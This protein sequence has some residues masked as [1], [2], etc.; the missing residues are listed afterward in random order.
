[1]AQK[2]NQKLLSKSL[3]D[4]HETNDD[5]TVSLDTDESIQLPSRQSLTAST[6]SFTESGRSMTPSISNYEVAKTPHQNFKKR[7]A[8]AGSLDTSEI[9]REILNRKPPDPFD[10]LPP[11]PPEPTDHIQTFFDA[12]ASTVRT[13]PAVSI[14]R[15]KLQISK[16][17]GEEELACAVSAPNNFQQNYT[18]WRSI[19]DQHGDQQQ[20]DGSDNLDKRSEGDKENQSPNQ[21]VE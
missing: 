7:S 18:V 6:Q 5:D 9:L 20:I 14:A 8:C 12:M 15:V 21:Q 10:F 16:I 3:S 4:I 11:K 17:V 1:M 2:S 13:F 19:S